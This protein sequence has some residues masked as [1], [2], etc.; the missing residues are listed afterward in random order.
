M[1]SVLQQGRGSLVNYRV[2]TMVLWY[3][4]TVSLLG[5]SEIE[6]HAKTCPCEKTSRWWKVKFTVIDR[7]SRH[8]YNNDCK[9]IA[10]KQRLEESKHIFPP[11]EPHEYSKMLIKSDQNIRHS[12][13]V[14]KNT[15]P[16]S[17]QV[18]SHVHMCEIQFTQSF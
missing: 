8:K 2:C 7:S 18:I 5:N 16:I 10:P 1:P 12:S 15:L 6:I 9:N 4:I 3:L 13:R 14:V 17:L 11:K